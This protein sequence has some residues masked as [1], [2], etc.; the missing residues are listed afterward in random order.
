MNARETR[1]AESARAY[2][3]VLLFVRIVRVLK[4]SPVLSSADAPAEYF[5][6]R[7]VDYRACGSS[8]LSFSRP[9]LPHALYEIDEL[10]EEV[11]YTGARAVL[12]AACGGIVDYVRRD[13]WPA[14]EPREHVSASFC[15]LAEF[16]EART[17]YERVMT[18]GGEKD[19]RL[20]KSIS[21]NAGFVADLHPATL[22]CP[23]MSEIY[24]VNTYIF[25]N[26][27]KSQTTYQHISLCKRP[28]YIRDFH[29]GPKGKSHLDI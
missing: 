18:R 7:S 2:K 12:C 1:T 5:I 24:F 9:K 14:Q 23:I 3:Y 6:S 27:R 19:T 29:N 11:F 28:L 26:I 4:I 10:R 22:L 17:A 20:V 15:S 13:I 8:P 21:E 16:R 25:I